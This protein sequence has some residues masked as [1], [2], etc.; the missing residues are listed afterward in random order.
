MKM[1]PVPQDGLQDVQAATEDDPESLSKFY[2]ALAHGTL[3]SARL[4]ISRGL[5]MVPT[6]PC[7]LPPQ[8]VARGLSYRITV[9][10]PRMLPTCDVRNP[11]LQ[12][13]FPLSLQDSA[14]F[15]ALLSSTLTHR[16]ARCLLGDESPDSF[17]Q[18]DRL[19]L[20]SCYAHT[21]RALNGAMRQ[22]LQDVR[23]ATI[24]AVLML[25]E[26]PTIQS[27]RDWTKSPVFQAPLRGM[28]WL[29][30]HGAREP[31]QAHQ[32]GLCRLVQLKG[33][34]PRIQL[35]GVA[36][37][38]SFRVLVNATLTL[39]APPLPFHPLAEGSPRTVR[40]F[41]DHCSDG[42]DARS[43]RMPSLGLTP[44]LAEVFEGMALYT[45]IVDRYVRG[46]IARPDTQEMCDQRN[47]I[48]HRLMSLPPADGS[49]EFDRFCEVCRVSA[50][51]YSIGVI[52]P[53]PAA[54]APFS[55]LVQT[56]RTNLGDGPLEAGWHLSVDKSVLL[57][58]ITIGGIAAFATPERER[59]VR[60][61][62][63]MT[64][65]AGLSEWSTLR[66]SLKM[67]PWLESACDAAGEKLWNEAQQFGQPK[68]VRS[69]PVRLTYG[70]RLDDVQGP[71]RR[72]PACLSC[73]SRGVKCNKGM[74]CQ[75]CVKHG[76]PCSYGNRDDTVVP[77]RVHI[78]SIRKQPCQLCKRRKVRCDKER[79]CQNCKKAGLT[80]TPLSH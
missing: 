44:D 50:I 63:G 77:A 56:L 7:P 64:V 1:L 5:E 74:P 27:E 23:D 65:D 67:M 79:P 33:G 59:F 41:L 75:S 25:V 34:L 80:C 68:Q 66:K 24:L 47:L 60:T 22:P 3:P 13:W 42:R 20:A 35:P 72:T 36:A 55:P 18:Q 62:H 28:Q 40:D 78:F 8:L 38:I 46:E 4:S 48:Q 76:T 51:I 61:L 17:D 57:W 21:V 53:L 45:A 32:S 9:M 29:N 54:T 43:D 49:S 26:S 11:Y 30:V 71:R 70:T 58:S 69:S 73:R 6:W 14:L 31:H 2:D 19:F 15:P 10:S 37:A 12:S 39:S 52:F 16:R